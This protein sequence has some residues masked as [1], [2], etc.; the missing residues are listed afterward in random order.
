MP[1]AFRYVTCS[2]VKALTA[3]GE[4]KAAKIK[5]NLMQSIFLALQADISL[6]SPLRAMDTAGIS[7]YPI[8]PF[9]PYLLGM[10]I[11]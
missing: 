4:L 11:P 3:Y 10:G 5:K 2:A 7:F 8:G 6:P 9:A 1:P